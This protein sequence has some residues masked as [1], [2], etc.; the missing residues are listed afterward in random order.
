MLLKLKKILLIPAILTILLYPLQNV[1]AGIPVIEAGP[2]LWQQIWNTISTTT[3]TSVSVW[4]QAKEVGKIIVR[5]LADKVILNSTQKIVN[6]GLTGFQGDPFYVRNQ[7]SL[8]ENIDDQQLLQ[9]VNA[10]TQTNTVNPYDTYKY[11]SSATGV[12]YFCKTQPPTSTDASFLS[13]NCKT[14]SDIDIEI[15]RNQN[16]NTGKLVAQSL[17]NTYVSGKESIEQKQKFNLDKVVGASWQDFANGDF[18]KGGWDAWDSYTQNSY[19]NPF[20]N[21]IQNSIDLQEMQTEKKEL[22]KQ[23]LIQ[24]NGFL[25]LKKCVEYKTSNIQNAGLNTGTSGEKKSDYKYKFEL[26]SGSLTVYCKIIPPPE[27]EFENQC[28]NS[29]SSLQS[30]CVATNRNTWSNKNCKTQQGLD[31]MNDGINTGIEGYTLASGEI[32]NCARYETTTPGNIINQQLTKALNAPLDKAL[33]SAQSGSPII[34][35]LTNLASDLI[36]NGLNNLVSNIGNTSSSTSI[37]SGGTIITSQPSQGGWYQPNGPIVILEDT[38][39]PGTASKELLDTIQKTETE[40]SLLSSTREL[41]QTFPV[42]TQLLDQCLPGPDFGWKNRLDDEFRKST[43]HLD[44]KA[45]KDNDKGDDAV[46]ALN[47]LESY[48]EDDA[49]NVKLSLL[50]F[51]G[52]NIASATLI[53]DRINQVTNIGT[54]TQEVV[55]MLVKRTSALAILQDIKNK[56]AQNPSK[57]VSGIFIQNENQNN[58]ELQKSYS[59]ISGS[60]T[61]EVTLD[62]SQARYDLLKKDDSNSFSRSN[63]DSLL[64]R[65]INERK[66]RPDLVGKDQG[67]TLFCS[68]Q[69]SVPSGT[70]IPWLFTDPTTTL[71]VPGAY[72]QDEHP[73]TSVGFIGIG[74]GNT[75]AFELD[76]TNFYKASQGDYLGN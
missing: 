16:N 48:K 64:S 3:D 11:P 10:I 41:L 7:A 1:S 59:Q 46:E 2:S 71:Y 63:P 62:D 26:I 19:N 23:E 60:V 36:F 21:L 43:L 18:S 66:V 44:K 24:N 38:T 33:G 69:T 58:E 35:S 67:Q 34:D 8:L 28:R 4:G 5:K 76:C 13:S 15:K 14:R 56:I 29:N 55:D 20:G 53:S 31:A 30:T 40:I 27:E 22:Q 49:N 73:Y 65:C 39:K 50:G 68:W 75:G 54:Q 45:N 25:S 70:T 72:T 61:N 32:D 74:A 37:N 12:S 6:W 9:T 42:K 52:Q 47:R 51:N 17:V 57:I